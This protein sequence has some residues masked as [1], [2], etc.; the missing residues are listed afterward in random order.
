M[1]SVTAQIDPEFMDGEG[2]LSVEGKSTSAQGSEQRE[3][4]SCGSLQ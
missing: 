3:D 2:D 1:G 4:S